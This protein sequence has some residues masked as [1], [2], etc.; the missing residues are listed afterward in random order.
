LPYD[1]CCSVFAPQHPLI[2]PKLESIKRSES[3]LNVEELIEKVLST[4]EIL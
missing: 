1:D 2:N 4:L 3:N